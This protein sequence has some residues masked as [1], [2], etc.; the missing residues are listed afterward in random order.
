M[1]AGE[2]AWLAGQLRQADALLDRSEALTEDA[3]LAGDVMLARWWV[4]T[5][6]SGPQPLFGR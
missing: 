2:A 1:L 6:G 5:S 3:E 4:A